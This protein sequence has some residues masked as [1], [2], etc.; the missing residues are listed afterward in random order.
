MTSPPRAGDDDTI[1][2]AATPPDGIA[3]GPQPTIASA[4]VTNGRDSAGSLRR[5]AAASRGVAGRPARHPASASVRNAAV[6]VTAGT[7]PHCPNSSH[8]ATAPNGT[9]DTTAR[10]ARPRVRTARSRPRARS[11]PATARSALCCSSSSAC[12]T[13]RPRPC[14]RAPRPRSAYQGDRTRWNPAVAAPSSARPATQ[15]SR[16]RRSA[17][18]AGVTRARPPGVGGSSVAARPSPISSQSHVL[19]S[20]TTPRDIAAPCPV[21]CSVLTEP[22]GL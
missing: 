14:T 2:G 10:T 5:M 18:H 20:P 22:S 3:T 7:R 13:H 1:M 4:S 16:T 19:G 8:A 15:G 9:S 6:H 11:D 12:T 21:A 17:T